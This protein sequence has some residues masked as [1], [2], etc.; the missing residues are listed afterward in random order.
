MDR[1]EACRRSAAV[2]DARGVAEKLGI[3]HYVLDLRDEFEKTIIEYFCKEYLAGRTPNPCVLCNAMIK[4]GVLLERAMEL[5]ASR[6]ATGHYARIERGKDGIYLLR[7]GFDVSKDQSYVL[8]RMNQRQLAH[9]LFPLGDLTKKQVRRIAEAAGLP[10][11]VD[12]E[13]QE[14]CFVNTESYGEFIE[15][16]FPSLENRG[17]FRYSDGRILGFHRGIHRYTVGQRKG[18]GISFK[19]PLYVFK[20]DPETNTVWVGP[21]A[22]LYNR[23]LIATDVNYIAGIPFEGERLVQAKIRYL[24]PLADAVA[25]PVGADSLKVT[26]K[27]PQKAITP[28]QSVVLY[29][30]DIVL[31]GGIISEVIG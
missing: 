30:G 3:P 25:T 23:G 7:R 29:D 26:F 6:I 4:F 24:S 14:V 22:E 31:G 11:A 5:G 16:R 12:A 28:G 27:E 21:E 1:A 19:H 9:A 8:Y 10:V 15:S 20:I 2:D 17:Y 18:L 13:S